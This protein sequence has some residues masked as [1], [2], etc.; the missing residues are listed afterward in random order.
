MQFDYKAAGVDLSAS[1]SAKSR[2]AEL[3]RRTHTS[4][5][6]HGPG[7]FG[8]FWDFSQPG[9]RQPVLVSSVD[10]VG[11]KVKLGAQLGRYRGLGI[12]LVNHCLNDIMVGGADPLFFLDYLAFGKL[13]DAVVVELVEGIAGACRAAGC[14]LIGGETAEMPEVYVPPEFDIAGT[15]VGVVDK[16]KIIDGSRIAAGDRLIGLAASGLHTNGFSLARRIV[17]HT[18]DLAPDRH[19]DDLGATV[20]EAL[21]APHR[22]YQTVIRNLREHTG[23][24]GF[25]HV[26][27]GG[28]AG[29]TRRLLRAGLSL[30]IDW[31]AWQWPP[32]FKL[33][34]RYGEV[35][36]EEM[37]AVFN[38]GIGLIIVVTADQI[39]AVSHK[40][41]EWEE[42]HWMIGRIT[43][44]DSHG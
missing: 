31:G 25:V 3:A 42:A 44:D 5:V 21:L 38:L 35:S 19:R 28:I 13:N 33:L 2:I 12:D 43:Q 23:V 17:A 39:A 30:Q 32:I 15:I 24:H 41:G 11:T 26:T 36:D 40:L 6:L 22:S 16:E 34:Q 10:G 27:G 8:G 20:G 29:N 7:L 14:A 4:R 37:R 9:C 1:D 18:P